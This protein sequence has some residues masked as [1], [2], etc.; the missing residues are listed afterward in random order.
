MK[1]NLCVIL[2]IISVIG[3]I[4]CF[5][6][7]AQSFWIYLLL[8]IAINIYKKKKH[9]IETIDNGITK[10]SSIY[11]SKPF[12]T[13][14]EMGF[15]KKLSRLEQYG[16]IV[17]PQVNLATII[18]KEN[19][20]FRS[21]LFRNIDFGI[22]NKEFNLKLLIELN[23]KT[24]HEYN[25]RNRYLMVKKILDECNIKLLNFYSNYPNEQSYVVNR[26]LEEIRKIDN[27][28]I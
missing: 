6:N 19:T 3:L 20:R 8:Y 12:L 28:N 7:G 18:E 23:D 4:L 9:Y 11:K 22:F 16:F 24:H 21:E 17:I 5:F 14:Y 26:V 27:I 15:Y 13:P 2:E 10:N 25:R 1:R